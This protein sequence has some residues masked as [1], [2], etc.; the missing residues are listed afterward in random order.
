MISSNFLNWTLGVTLF[1]A[2]NS[3][4]SRKSCLVPTSEPTTSIP[5]S[6]NLGIS[7]FILSTGKPTATTLAPAFTTS[8]AWLN[9]VLATEV[10]TVASNPLLSVNFITS[11]TGSTSLELIIASA[12]N[13]F[14][15]ANL[16]SL[17][18][19][20]TILAPITF[21]AYCKARL[22]KPPIPKTPNHCPGFTLLTFTAL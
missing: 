20:A 5:S 13:S 22:P 16:S 7:K 14:A 12:P 9:G 19:K 4:A 10:T 1:S 3:N 2:A 8:T 21:L 6:T 11:A 18:S 15:N 17:M